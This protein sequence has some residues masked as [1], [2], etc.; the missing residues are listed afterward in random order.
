[1]LHAGHCAWQQ[2][3]RSVAIMSLLLLVMLT[4]TDGV[5]ASVSSTVC[6]DIANLPEVN[7]S[8]VFCDLDEFDDAVGGWEFGYPPCNEISNTVGMV[9]SPSSSEEVAA[10]VG[11]IYNHNTNMEDTK[12]KLK[13]SVRSGGH[14]GTCNSIIEGSIHLDLRQLN[15]LDIIPNTLDENPHNKE[16]NLL[17]M[18]TGNTFAD[19]FEVVD[20]N[21]YTL[22]YGTC[23]SVGVGGFYLH[24]GN[25][26]M[27]KFY[28]WG[29]E[30]IRAMT[31]VTANGTVLKFKESR[32]RLLDTNEEIT[33]QVDTRDMANNSTAFSTN[34]TSDGSLP[35]IYSRDPVLIYDADD[36]PL[37]EAD[38]LH[39]QD[40]WTA[41]RVAGSSFGI[42]T[43]LTIQM[44]ETPTPFFWQIGVN[45]TL[46]EE[47]DILEDAIHDETVVLAWGRTQF[48]PGVLMA[49]TNINDPTDKD[50][51]FEACLV[52]LDEWFLRQGIDDWRT[53]RFAKGL[54]QTVNLVFQGR[55]DLTDFGPGGKDGWATSN[56]VFRA[57]IPERN[58][59][60]SWY[61]QQHVLN[62]SDCLLLVQYMRST[63]T[64][65]PQLGVEFSCGPRQLYKEMM[66]Q[67][68]REVQARYP[69]STRRGNMIQ[70]MCLIPSR[71]SQLMSITGK[72]GRKALVQLF[73]VLFL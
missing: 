39:Y 14:S 34:S 49:R 36:N 20:L 50:E 11:Y 57:D 66:R 69:D 37:N 60:L 45:L 71:V 54:T 53:T 68:E 56:V 33:E 8:H 64:Q 44:Y 58:E 62:A 29:N 24:G 19:I 2:P 6:N 31:V 21:E 32:Q 30:T 23:H 67:V 35:P 5:H 72:T 27:S 41:L 59:I 51:S 52:W 16:T 70:V 4:N 13:L 63:V 15:N 26:P 40:L 22:L 47:L 3:R 73:W 7:A 18:G 1:M 55:L 25:Y 17:Q 9:V 65:E 61:Q 28:G 42:V 12:D 10:V 43:E 48:G 38:S 46:Q